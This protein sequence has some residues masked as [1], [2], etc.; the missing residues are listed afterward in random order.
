VTGC[1]A[2]AICWRP[3]HD[4]L[5]EHS[6]SLAKPIVRHAIR[7]SKFSRLRLTVRIGPST[8][9]LHPY[10]GRALLR[11]ARNRFTAREMA[12]EVPASGAP[13]HYG[14]AL[15]VDCD[16]LQITLEHPGFRRRA[17]KQRC[18]RIDCSL[19]APVRSHKNIDSV[20]FATYDY[21]SVATYRDRYDPSSKCR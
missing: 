2:I 12:L 20:G 6:D 1:K 13:S 15:R 3:S 11:D 7:S 21:A 8:C 16:R 4:R 10:V 14:L 5:E 18:D 17:L 19:P 9:R